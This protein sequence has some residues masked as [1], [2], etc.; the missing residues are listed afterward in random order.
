MTLTEHKGN[1][2]FTHN[3]PYYAHCIA[4][5]LR[6]GAGIAV[7]FQ[8]RF[9]LRGKILDSGL[10]L[11]SPT[12]VLAGKVFN[13]I[14]K[15]KSTGKPTA[16]SLRLAV[17]KMKELAVSICVDRI[18]MPRIGCGLERLSWAVVRQILKQEFVGTNISLEVYKL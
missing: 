17:R 10:P 12:C 1:V 11:R 15:S 8:L 2:F 5:D 14:T 4:S 18:V 3:D 7:Q 16:M 13:L 6:M 9:G